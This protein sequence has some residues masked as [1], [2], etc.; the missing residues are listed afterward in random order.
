RVYDRA[1]RWGRTRATLTR[2]R[3]RPSRGSRF[4]RYAA[5]PARLATRG[6]AM[7]ESDTSFAV[8]RHAMDR[9]R[10]RRFRQILLWPLQLMPLRDDVQ[11]HRHWEF[12]AQPSPDNPWREVEDE[13]TGDPGT[14]QERHYAEFVN[15]LPYVQRVLYG[16]GRGIQSTES[17]IRVFRRHDVRA[18]RITLDRNGEPV[19]LEIAHVD[20]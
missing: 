10:G 2:W 17:P 6:E 13:F 15:F 7:P 3:W 4:R 1:T 16:E 19:E 14:F 11:I 5:A 18:V 9:A 8:E 20:L 12:L